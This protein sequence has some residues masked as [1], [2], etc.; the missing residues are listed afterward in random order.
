MNSDFNNFRFCSGTSN[1]PDENLK[2]FFRKCN[3]VETPFNHSDLKYHGIYDF[4]KLSINKNSSLATLHLHIAS[5]P[6][7]F[8][9]LQ[10]FLSF[11]KYPF[12][13]IEFKNT[14]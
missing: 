8:E 12:D 10:N 6:K 3:S 2:S 7:H 1:F 11:L 14:K 9:D 4:N 5:V 13:I